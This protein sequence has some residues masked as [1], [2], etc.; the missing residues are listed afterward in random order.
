MKE[1]ITKEQ[2]KDTG[3][4]AILILLLS[5]WFSKNLSFIAPAIIALITTMTWPTLFRP[6]AVFWFGLSHFMGEFVS[7]ILMT[8]VFLLVATPIGVLRK[9]SGKDAMGLKK[10]KKDTESTFSKRDHTFTPADLE[11]PF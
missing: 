10:W 7:R 9:I 8:I 11:K 1:K 4:A 3:L 2:C 6:L 5:G